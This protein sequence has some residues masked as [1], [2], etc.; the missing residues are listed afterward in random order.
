MSN[1]IKPV[2]IFVDDE[3]DLLDIYK[4]HFRKEVAANRINLKC[5]ENGQICYD[6][7]HNNADN[8]KIIFIMSD[9]NMPV[10]DGLS[11]L[12]KIK[13]SY[14]QFNVYMGSAYGDKKTIEKAKS[15]GAT[16]FFVKPVNMDVI[17][18]LINRLLIDL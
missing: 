18:E 9:I 15:L 16:D 14:P 3:T 17:R 4:V 7:I 2:V 11:L 8:E 10:M 1:I 13:E 5:F 12:Q 6:Y